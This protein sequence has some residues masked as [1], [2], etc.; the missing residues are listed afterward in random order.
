MVGIG[1]IEAT[2]WVLAELAMNGVDANKRTDRPEAD[3]LNLEYRQNCHAVK[4]GKVLPLPL[5]PDPHREVVSDVGLVVMLLGFALRPILR[6]LRICQQQTPPN[7]RQG[8]Y[9]FVSKSG[10]YLSKRRA[11]QQ[12]IQPFRPRE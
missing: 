8:C 10:R 4:R 5:V 6:G 11:F 12:P 3:M 9:L 2:G 7:D 1:T